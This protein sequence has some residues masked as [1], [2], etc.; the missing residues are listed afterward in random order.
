KTALITGAGRGLG[1]ALAM[2]FAAEGALLALFDKSASVLETATVLPVVSQLHC[3][4]VVDITDY[5]AVEK[6]LAEAWAHLQRFDILVNNAGIF[7]N[8]TLLTSSLD[9]WRQVVA[10][11]LEAVYMFSKLVVPRMVAAQ[12]GRIINVASIAGFASR[13]NVGSYNASKGG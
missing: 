2:Q 10:V 6:A 8:G 9:E 1:R 11:N 7:F 4:F 13:G 12:Q 5:A 3:A